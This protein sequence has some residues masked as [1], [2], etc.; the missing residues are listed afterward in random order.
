[1]SL[2]KRKVGYVYSK[3]W[4]EVANL[5]PSNEGRSSLVHELAKA[6]NLFDYVQ[7]IE[8]LSATEDDLSSF[9]DS[10]FSK[11]LLEYDGEEGE[12]ILLEEYGLAYDCPPFPELSLY[13]R[14]LAGSSLAAAESLVS[15]NTDVAINWDGGRHHARRGRSAGFC[16]INDI[17]LAIMHLRKEFD[18]VLYID[19]DL[20]A[21]DGVESAFLHSEKVYTLSFHRFDKGFYPNTGGIDS[22]GKGKGIHTTLNIPLKRGLNDKTFWRLFQALVPLAKDSFC[23]DAVVVQLG[24]DGENLL[25]DTRLIMKGLIRDPHKEWNLTIKS[26]GEAVSRI[27]AWNLPTLLLGG[28]GYSSVDTAR[29]CS[30]LTSIACNVLLSNEI[31][32]HEYWT[33]YG[34]DYELH[35]EKS[36]MTEENTEDYLMTILPILKNRIS[37]LG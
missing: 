30:Y 16:Y 19:F 33:S 4:E 7:L 1:M 10:E 6:Y 22:V 28:G 37:R 27:L 24:C 26:F 17:V 23:P 29:C 21:A 14:L 34:S 8:P 36:L 13:T 18:K 2:T 25:L 5:L 15:G 11:F 20:H 9:H 32:H 35:F 12:D 31:P 3:E